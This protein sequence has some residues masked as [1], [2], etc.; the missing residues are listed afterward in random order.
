YRVNT[1]VSHGVD[2]GNWWGDQTP[3]MRNEDD[4]CIY[5]DSD[6]MAEKLE[7]VGTPLVS[8]EIEP[9]AELVHWVVRLEDIAPDGTS[10]FVTG[11]AV[12]GSQI[13]DRLFPRKNIIGGRGKIILPMHFTTWVFEK[14][15]R[16]RLAIANGQFPMLWPAPSLAV[17]RVFTGAFSHLALPG[18]VGGKL[19]TMPPVAARE[20]A[21]DVEV[22]E[23][24][25]GPTQVE[26]D[27]SQ[28]RVKVSWEEKT[29]F[30]IGS[31]VFNSGVRT[32]SEVRDNHS[33]HAR[34][35][36]EMERGVMSNGRGVRVR[37]HI[38]VHSDERYFHVQVRREVQEN[39]FLIRERIWREDILRDF[40]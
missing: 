30:K 22:L 15:H 36:G 9:G 31:K 3:D 19:V 17:N 8:L 24:T 39:G 34:F 28:G 33:A 13:V 18:T 6:V 5:F 38:D 7:I 29:R 12:N 16:V 11:A 27:S 10:H 37:S 26:R 32:E 14:G 35:R 40:Q 23:N 2:A 20:V 21:P 4:R 25:S 1:P